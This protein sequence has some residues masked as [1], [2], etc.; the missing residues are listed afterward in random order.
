MKNN[1]QVDKVISTIVLWYNDYPILI[2][3][4]DTGIYYNNQVGGVMCQQG[5][6]EGFIIPLPINKLKDIEILNPEFWA[7]LDWNKEE[8]F[9]LVDNKTKELVERI[10]SLE[11]Y[12]LKDFQI[13]NNATE[14][15]FQCKFVYD[16]KT[17]EGILTWENSD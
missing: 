13:T 7:G 5:H 9:M 10:N 4:T 14:A 2:A 17:F 8:T 12:K 11:I 15:W 1:Q 16:D 6:I 3:K